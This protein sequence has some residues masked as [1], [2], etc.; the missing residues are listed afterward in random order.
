MLCQVSE[1]FSFAWLDGV[2]QGAQSHNK[3]RYK[4]AH[5]KWLSF[6]WVWF[7][8][9][10]FGFSLRFFFSSLWF[11]GRMLIVTKKIGCDII[12]DIS[13]T[14]L[15]FVVAS[16]YIYHFFRNIDR[17]K[18]EWFTKRSMHWIIVL[19]ILPNWIPKNYLILNVRLN[20]KIIISIY[21]AVVQHNIFSDSKR[22]KSNERKHRFSYCSVHANTFMVLKR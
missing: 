8:L 5:S 12:Y 3:H 11:F 18:I 17:D 14:I 20:E 6:D 2:S 1:H 13:F 15:W 22:C 10:R 21:I 4:W 16:S 9:V 7:V 19:W